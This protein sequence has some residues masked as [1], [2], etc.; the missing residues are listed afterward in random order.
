[1]IFELD[2][3]ARINGDLL[4]EEILTAVPGA[5]EVSVRLTRAGIEVTIQGTATLEEISPVVAAHNPPADKDLEAERLAAESARAA[6]NS[7]LSKAQSVKAGGPGF[8]AAE[9]S[10]IMSNLVI[11]ISSGDEV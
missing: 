2:A 4:E 9:I 6:I 8:T 1:M 7:M 3:P 5:E 11:L 10:T